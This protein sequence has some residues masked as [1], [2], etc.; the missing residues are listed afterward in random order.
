ME[1]KIHWKVILSYS[2]LLNYRNSYENK[3]FKLVLL[4]ICAHFFSDF[5]KVSDII[6]KYIREF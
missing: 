6:P 3:Q 1:K 4:F 5:A 2:H